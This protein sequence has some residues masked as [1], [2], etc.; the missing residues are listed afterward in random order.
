MIQIERVIDKLDE[1]YASND[2]PGGERHLDYWLAE[3]EMSR[4]VKGQITVLSEQ[5][6]LCRMLG[7]GE[8][9]LS[10]ADRVLKLLEEWGLDS[11]VSGATVQ[12]NCATVYAAFGKTEDSIG[13]F[14]K[15]RTVFEANLKEDDELFGSLYNNYAAG[16]KDLGR[17]S[18]AIAMY[19]KALD[20]M[21]KAPD[22]QC[23]QAVTYLNMAGVVQDKDGLWDGCEEIEKYVRKAEELITDPALSRNVHY[24][25]TCSKCIPAFR[26]Y[27]YFATADE[28][29]KQ[30]NEIYAGN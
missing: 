25:I 1:Y 21:G 15:A 20:I 6:G 26:Y 5:A 7:K 18:D 4:D 19:E 17:F 29:E 28:L 27:G 8:K 3:A 16:L 30:A 22:G 23:E 13:I 10:C 14:E 24:A 2:L 11:T 9:A 12:I